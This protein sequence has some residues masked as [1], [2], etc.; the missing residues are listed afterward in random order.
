MLLKDKIERLTRTHNLTALAK[1]AH[2][3]LS[4]LRS[5]IAGTNEPSRRT[6]KALSSQ[7]MIDYAWLSDDSKNWPPVRIVEPDHA[8]PAHAA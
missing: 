8:E 3:S 5:I 2:I 4:T 1:E 6:I 7:L